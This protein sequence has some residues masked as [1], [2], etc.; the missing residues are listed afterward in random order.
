MKFKNFT[1][2]DLK[3]ESSFSACLG[4]RDSLVHTFNLEAMA[5]GVHNISVVAGLA[6]DLENCGSNVT[7]NMK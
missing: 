7:L 1:G 4:A 5:L 6:R 3:G 2:G